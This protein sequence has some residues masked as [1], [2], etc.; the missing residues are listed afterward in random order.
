VSSKQLWVVLTRFIWIFILLLIGHAIADGP[1]QRWLELNKRKNR[2]FPTSTMPWTLAM[3]VHAGTH[4]LFVMLVTRSVLLGIGEFVAHWLTDDA[5]CQGK[6]GTIE[7]QMIHVACKAF[8]AA[9][10]TI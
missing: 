5:K 10:V 6:I 1:L 3:T 4:A 9:V 7:D 8:W 2:R